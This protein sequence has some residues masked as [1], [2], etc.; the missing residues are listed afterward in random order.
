AAS[1]RSGR[2]AGLAGGGKDAAAL[3]GGG[4]EAAALAGG[5]AEA[6]ALTGGGAE[7]AALGGGDETAPSASSTM[8]NVRPVRGSWTCTDS[9][10]ST[11]QATFC[12]SAPSPT[13]RR[14]IL[15][16]AI[17]LSAEIRSVSCRP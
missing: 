6:A 14:P 10:A 2:A 12:G 13:L 15:S 5:G 11:S 9:S 17:Q 1:S 8:R 7:A 3:T 4:A 16:A